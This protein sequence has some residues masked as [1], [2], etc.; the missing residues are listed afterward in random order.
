MKILAKDICLDYPIVSSDLRSFKMSAVQAATGGLLATGKKNIPI[1]KAL[2]NVNFAL[3]EGDRLGL[4]GHNGSGKSTLLKVL[5]GIYSPT[6]GSL[7]SQGRIVSIL[8]STLGMNPEATGYANIINHGLLFGLS[9][10][11][12]MAKLPE[13]AE[14]TELGDYLHLPVRT[15]SKGMGTRTAFGVVTSVDAEILLMDEVIETGDA[16]FAHK[17]RERLNSLMSRC[18]ILVLATHS[19]RSIR[20]L[21]NK[22]LLLEQGEVLAIGDI[23]EVYRTYCERY[24]LEE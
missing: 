5:A 15:Y 20:S 7:A 2:R 9:R 6:S 18:K 4:L 23:D 21:C 10:K 11:Q 13:I 12:I 22:A 19:I 14:F 1:V 16:A 8:N 3:Y 24:N 17:A